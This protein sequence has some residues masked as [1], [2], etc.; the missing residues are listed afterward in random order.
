VPLFKEW[1]ATGMPPGYIFNAPRENYCE[2]HEL[3]LNLCGDIY[4]ALRH[5]KMKNKWLVWSPVWKPTCLSVSRGSNFWANSCSNY[6]ESMIGRM[7]TS[8]FFLPFWW[9]STSGH[10]PKKYLASVEIIENL[11][12]KPDFKLGTCLP[13]VN[14]FW[15]CN[16]IWWKF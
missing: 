2:F 7:L 11:A 14:S 10:H 12:E 5:L 8:L 4:Q 16:Q 6:A 3:C 15:R 9:W 13:M 1:V